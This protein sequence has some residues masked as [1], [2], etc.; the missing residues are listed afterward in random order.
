MSKKRYFNFPVQLLSGFMLNS[1][2]V[3]SDI[4]NYAVY[5]NSISLE[6]GD[7]MDKFESS[8]GY[9][10]I[11]IVNIEKALS[12]GQELYDSIPK[13]SPKVGL[14]LKIYWDYYNNEKTEFEKVCLLGFLAL[15]S[16]LMKKPY[17]KMTNKYW[18]SRMDGKA[19]SVEKLELSPEIKKY[20]NEYQTKKIKG[21]LEDN[22]KLI[23]YSQYTYGFFVSFKMEYDPLVF[24][25][26]KQRKSNKEKRK[27]EAKRKAIKSA[28]DRLNGTR[29]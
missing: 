28:M 4:A 24:E 7:D 17:C 1:R 23:T 13:G 10:D 12:D 27:K 11:S 29:P 8:M 16:I 9:F 15:R 22:W 6:Y 5:E 25:A 2:K 14:R 19:K 20:A 3:L 21:E 26:E 18:L